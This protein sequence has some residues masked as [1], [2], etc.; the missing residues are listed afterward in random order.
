MR[1]A[2][3]CGMA[4]AV[5]AGCEKPP[6]TREELLAEAG[7]QAS[8]AGTLLAQGLRRCNAIGARNIDSCASQKGNLVDETSAALLAQVAIDQRDAYFAFCAPKL[9]RE[10]CNDLLGRA[11]TLAWNKGG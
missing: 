10:Y 2:V 6:P 5:L 4:L 9:G 3:L 1:V 8:V 11:A 7:T